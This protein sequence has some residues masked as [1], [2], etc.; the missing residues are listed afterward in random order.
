[1]DAPELPQPLQYLDGFG[2]AAVAVPGR[3]LR[4]D[5]RDQRLHAHQVPVGRL[6]ART[7]ARPASGRVAHANGPRGA[8]VGVLLQAPERIVGAGK[9]LG[10]NAEKAAHGCRFPVLRQRQCQPGLLEGRGR[11]P[12]LGSVLQRAGVQ[13]AAA[14]VFVP[15]LDGVPQRRAA[16][17]RDRNRFI[18]T[19]PRWRERFTSRTRRRDCRPD[20]NPAQPAAPTDRAGQA[21]AGIPAVVQPFAFGESPSGPVGAAVAGADGAVRLSAVIRFQSALGLPHTAAP[22]VGRTLRPLPRRLWTAVRQARRAGSVVCED[23]QGVLS[24]AGRRGGLVRGAHQ[25]H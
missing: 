11:T 14:A 4:R 24:P 5:L 17:N 18:P 6:A 8:G 12:L 16:A 2:D 13:R 10:G 21:P 20:G 23:Q 7:A 22:G 9:P 1:M 19:D 25:R 3:L 15:E